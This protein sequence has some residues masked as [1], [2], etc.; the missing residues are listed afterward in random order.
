MNVKQFF[1]KNFLQP[2]TDEAK[3]VRGAFERRHHKRQNSPRVWLEIYEA[4]LDGWSDCIMQQL[5]DS[6]K[7]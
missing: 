5:R 6:L 3:K 4:Y 7:K 2:E 1:A